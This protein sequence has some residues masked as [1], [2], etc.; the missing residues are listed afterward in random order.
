LSIKGASALCLAVLLSVTAAAQQPPQADE[1]NLGRL[2]S[3]AAQRARLDQIRAALFDE[4]ELQDLLSA[5]ELMVEEEEPVEALAVIQL[6]GIVRHNTGGHTVWLNGVAVLEE[7]LP[8]GAR[9]DYEGPLAV[10]QVTQGARNFTLK[11]G[12]SL[13]V[14]AGTIQESYQITAEQVAAI[15]AAL[16]ARAAQVR[17]SAQRS[18]DIQQAQAS[19]DGR[20]SEPANIPDEE[21]S[22][23]QAVLQT[24]QQV[25]QVQQAAQGVVP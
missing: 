25:Q 7:N 21:E 4:R 5:A 9:V 19:L 6:G 10:L 3:T 20:E 15:Q 8:A 12:Q 24:L 11:T 22:M 13:D 23:V 18:A 2:F 17:Q 14:M 16:A 1:Q